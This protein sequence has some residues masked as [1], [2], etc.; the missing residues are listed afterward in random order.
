MPTEEE[1]FY[2]DAYRRYNDFLLKTVKS[3]AETTFNYNYADFLEDLLGDTR[4][5]LR[6]PITAKDRFKTHSYQ[7]KEPVLQTRK[8]DGTWDNPQYT[9][10]EKDGF[11]KKTPTTAGQTGTLHP[12]VYS[13]KD[14]VSTGIIFFSENLDL[15]REHILVSEVFTQNVSSYGRPLTASTR[16]AALGA[17]KKEL[18]SGTMQPTVGSLFQVLQ[19]SSRE[20]TKTEH[21]EVLARLKWIQGSK[22]QI[23]IFSDPNDLGSSLFAQLHAM[24]LMLHTGQSFVGISYYDRTGTPPFRPYWLSKQAEDLEAA[25]TSGNETFK[26]IAT[27]IKLFKTQPSPLTQMELDSKIKLCKQLFSIKELI[28][29]TTYEKLVLD[30]MNQI[31]TANSEEFEELKQQLPQT[32]LKPFLR[33]L[34]NPSSS[35]DKQPMVA[36]PRT[37]TPPSPVKDVPKKPPSP[38]VQASQVA[39]PR[40]TTPPPSIDENKLYA[41]VY[42]KHRN[43]LFKSIKADSDARYTYGYP[44]FIEDVT[45]KTHTPLRRKLIGSDK[46]K[47]AMIDGKPT[48]QLRKDGRWTPSQFS[49]KEKKGFSKKTGVT[50]GNTDVYLPAVFGTNSTRTKEVGENQLSLIGVIFFSDDLDQKDDHV[51]VSSVYTRDADSYNR[52]GTEA[53]RSGAKSTFDRKIKEGKQVKDVKTLLD[54]AKLGE[55]DPQV[56]NE[57]LARLKWVP[58]DPRCQVGIFHD[59]LR[60]RLYAQLR[61]IDW[62]V[63]T[64]QS[65]VPISFYDRLKN[66]PFSPYLTLEQEKDLQLALS[67]KD[68]Q[69]KVIA[70]IIKCHKD[71]SFLSTMSLDSKIE[72]C[73]QL[74]LMHPPTGTPTIT[75]ITYEK[76]VLDI[77]SQL[78]ANEK[79]FQDLK[80][81]IPKTIERFSKVVQDLQKVDE[82]GLSTEDNASSA[83]FSPTSS[84]V[85]RDSEQDERL[86]DSK[87]EQIEHAWT[88][89]VKKRTIEPEEESSS[90]GE[91]SSE[92]GNPEERGLKSDKDELEF[93][94]LTETTL[95]SSSEF[96]DLLKELDAKYEP[97]KKYLPMFP[98]LKDMNA[99]ALHKKTGVPVLCIAVTKGDVELVKMLL[100]LGAD[101]NVRNPFDKNPDG[102]GRT[103]LES[104]QAKLSTSTE[105]Y[106]KIIELLKKAEKDKLTGSTSGKTLAE[107]PLKRS[108]PPTG[109]PSLMGKLERLGG[110]FSDKIPEPA[111]PIEPEPSPAGTAK[112]VP[113]P[114][115]ENTETI[116]S[117][118][119]KFVNLIDE[120]DKISNN[121]VI[122]RKTY[123]EMFPDLIK[124]EKDGTIT[125]NPDALHDLTKKTKVAVIC[126]AVARGD[127]ALVKML[128]SLKADI[129]VRNAYDQTPLVAAQTKLSDPSLSETERTKYE[130]IRSSLLE[131]SDKESHGL[132]R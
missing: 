60:S 81:K 32:I 123:K 87:L 127:V 76:Y 25:L 21:N 65:F 71:Q 80:T 120:L 23:G 16:S 106:L 131:Y 58:G 57:T 84:Y 56:H 2:A 117:L 37:T 62:M 48:T 113:I 35:V 36:S 110:E 103:P 8:P 130:Q 30:I 112:F 128:L 53:T 7:E 13:Q 125:I 100:S 4:N 69:L 94:D 116:S 107:D 92:E 96:N 47:M 129:N 14:S 26:K 20:S 61:A 68:P 24:D 3:E 102:E 95:P 33:I 78:Q 31:K 83:S 18:A 85:S 74:T 79:E 67:G 88:E 119:F 93:E 108:S 132:K 70:T 109:S 90:L 39:S 29:T 46:A 75:K 118:S 10:K 50:V 42:K 59:N 41:D 11:T 89:E 6:R 91:I 111:K 27:I 115:S 98:D 38:V 114:V 43:F 52:G 51:L 55:V 28:T 54:K 49:K 45:G 22:C 63:N 82:N 44:N 73:K 9:E 126:I 64:D 15:E 34:N 5:P 77:M 40:T 99:N 12:G 124:K 1:Q 121:P 86:S 72:L 17:A 101:I 19:Y 105:K 66:P 122:K 97:G 104:A